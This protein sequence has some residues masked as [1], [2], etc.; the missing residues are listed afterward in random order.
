MKD[1]TEIEHLDYLLT[2]AKIPH[3]FEPLQD[4]YQIRIYADEAMTEELDDAICHSGSHGYEKGLLET[5]VLNEC[6]G[7]ETADQV[8]DGW[9]KMYA[10]SC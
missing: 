7:Y 10:N 9:Q 6:E 1:F 8:F 4:G 2:E 3:T 5:F